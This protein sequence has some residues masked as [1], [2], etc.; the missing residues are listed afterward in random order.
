MGHWGTEPWANDPAADWYEAFFRSTQLAEHIELTL[1]LDINEHCDEVRAAAYVLLF[2]G[3]HEIWPDD[4]RK[5][6]L[7]IAVDQLRKALETEL[8]T[9]PDIIKQ[10]QGEIRLL[11]IRLQSAPT[12]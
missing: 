9:N 6:C 7:S 10:V 2:L 4:S 1:T 5:R 8:F 3:R 12:E 11:K